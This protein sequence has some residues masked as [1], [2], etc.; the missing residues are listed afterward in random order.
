MVCP[1]PMLHVLFI[2]FQLHINS[3]TYAYIWH[4]E[5]NRWNQLVCAYP[6][7][8]FICGVMVAMSHKLS[9]QMLIVLPPSE[10][11]KLLHSET[12]N[13]FINALWASSLLRLRTSQGT[14]LCR[15]ERLKNKIF[16][17]LVIMLTCFPSIIISWTIYTWFI[18]NFWRH[19]LMLRAGRFSYFLE[20]I[21]VTILLRF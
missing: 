18:I 12:V 13:E 10:K 15:R 19:L 21:F 9:M 16:E 1:I 4:A 14:M 17:H 20:A 8:N 6:V 2:L 11:Y 3:L 7:Y 5:A